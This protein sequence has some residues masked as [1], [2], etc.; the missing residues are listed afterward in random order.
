MTRFQ[1]IRDVYGHWPTRAAVA[2]GINDAAGSAQVT[3]DQVQKWA[4]KN[5]VPGKYWGW[6][7]KAARQQGVALTAD[8]LVALHVPSDPQSIQH[9]GDAA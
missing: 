1:S 5:A 6:L 3:T 7:L 9:N 8:D 4:E 2:R